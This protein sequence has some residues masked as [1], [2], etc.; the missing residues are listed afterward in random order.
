MCKIID[1]LNR[2]RIVHLSYKALYILLVFGACLIGCQTQEIKNNNDYVTV[3]IDESQFKDEFLLSENIKIHKVIR[4]ETNSD[5]PIGNIDNLQYY[6]SKIYILDRLKARSIFVFDSTGAFQNKVSRIGKGPGEFFRPTNFAF[7]GT[8]NK[9]YILDGNFRK[10]NIYDD[11]GAF[12]K[13][14]QIEF[15]ASDLR[16][17]Q[18]GNINFSGRDSLQ[19]YITDPNG[20]VIFKSLENIRQFSH[21]LSNPLSQLGDE[22]LFIRNFDD[23]IYSVVNNKLSPKY[24]IDFGENSITREDVLKQNLPMNSF[25]FYDIK[26]P[27]KVMHSVRSANFN[28]E[29]LRFHFRHGKDN[30]LNIIKKKDSSLLTIKSSNISNDIFG[31]SMYTSRYMAEDYFIGL[32]NQSKLDENSLKELGNYIDVSG[33]DEYSNPILVFYSYD[34]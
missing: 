10:V 5:C 8:T 19:F 17:S 20:Q 4:L 1:I 15:F 12:E 28:D 11:S 22:V 26:I 9:I 21:T 24:F 25:G 2:I 29:Y 27:E 32:I 23:T 6:N 13:A 30:Y 7:D 3:K 33:L 18:N 34:F 16:I 31:G 14:I